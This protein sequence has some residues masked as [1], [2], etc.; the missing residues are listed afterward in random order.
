MCNM[1]GMLPVH[2]FCLLM[3]SQTRKPT[4]N[5]RELMTKLGNIVGVLQ[6]IQSTMQQLQG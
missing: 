3:S 6:Q 2:H 4:L 1:K 5:G